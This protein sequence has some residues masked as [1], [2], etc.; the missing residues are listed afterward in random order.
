MKFKKIFKWT[1][2]I[3]QLI[4]VIFVLTIHYLSDEKMGVMRSLTYR[5][6]VYDKLSLRL[7]IIYGLILLLIILVILSV[8]A[9]K[10]FNK[11][12]YSI[13]VIAITLCLILFGVIFNSQV[14]LSYYVIL[15]GFSIVLVIE[16]LKIIFL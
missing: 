10:K 11:F 7:K 4:L 12:K 6:S 8:K 3:I 2:T 15:I 13:G 14:L 1:S 5:N 9:Y 16:L